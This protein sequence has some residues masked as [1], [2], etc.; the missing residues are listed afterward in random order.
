MGESNY[1]KGKKKVSDEELITALDKAYKDGGEDKISV[2]PTD[3]SQF[4]PIKRQQVGN[5]LH[6]LAESNKKICKFKAGRE[7]LYYS[8]NW[9]EIQNMI[10]NG[11]IK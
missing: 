2:T 5:R 10:K 9:E 6:K 7:W 4:L 3:V 1:P 8:K 11:Y